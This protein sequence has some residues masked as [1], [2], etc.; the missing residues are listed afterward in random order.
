MMGWASMAS[1]AEDYGIPFLA[2][3]SLPPWPKGVPLEHENF[4]LM[5]RMVHGPE[6]AADIVEAAR[7]FHPDVAVI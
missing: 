6:A 3:P 4:S 1:R 7:N 5:G 2:Y